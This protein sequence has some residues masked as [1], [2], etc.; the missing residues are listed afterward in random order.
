MSKVIF[1]YFCLQRQ[2]EQFDKS[3][4]VNISELHKQGHKV[5]KV[6]S[7]RA[8]FKVAVFMIVFFLGGV[9]RVEWLGKYGSTHYFCG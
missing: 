7:L 5:I 2:C 8:C 9:V 1:Y 4:E 6:S 3:G